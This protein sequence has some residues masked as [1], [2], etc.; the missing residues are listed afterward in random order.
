M[1]GTE[2]SDSTGPNQNSSSSLWIYHHFFNPPVVGHW[3]CQLCLRDRTWQLMNEDTQWL[4]ESSRVQEN[5]F[6]PDPHQWREERALATCHLC[7]SALDLGATR[8][9]PF[10]TLQ[11][12]S[13]PVALP[14]CPMYPTPRSLR[15]LH[16]ATLCHTLPVHPSPW[17]PIA[18]SP[19]CCPRA[20]W[21]PAGLD[22]RK[23]DLEGIG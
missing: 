6:S 10:L 14:T 4:A 1:K 5:P 11:G 9:I 18:F 19:V 20:P 12:A 17:H 22:C 7:P 15:T 2:T 16:S 23:R 8:G 21:F 3:S 13:I